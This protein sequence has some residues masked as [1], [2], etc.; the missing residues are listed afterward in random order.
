[1]ILLFMV[2]TLLLL[3]KTRFI[4][5]MHSCGCSSIL[6]L[7]AVLVQLC[8]AVAACIKHFLSVLDFD[9]INIIY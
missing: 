5:S 1:M 4:M 2:G 8:F 6:H 7:Y 3:C 9:N